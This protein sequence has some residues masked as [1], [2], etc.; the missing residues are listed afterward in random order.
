MKKGVFRKSLSLLLSAA[1]ALL[2]F[3]P[4]LAASDKQ[5]ETPVLIVTGFAEYPLG[6][7]QTGESAFPPETQDI[8]NTVAGAAPALLRLL[9]SDR[10]QADYDALCDAVLPVVNELFD[11]IACNPDGTVRHSDVGLLYQ[12]P[13]SA[14]DYPDGTIT[15]K[16][17]E[18]T[19]DQTSAVYGSVP[20]KLTGSYV[21][22]NGETQTGVTIT[23]T[24]R[25]GAVWPNA[26][27]YDLTAVIDDEFMQAA[28]LGSHCRE[29]EE[30]VAAVNVQ[31]VGNRTHTVRRIDVAVAVNRVIR[32]PL[33]FSVGRRTH[34]EFATGL[35]AVMLSV[36][37]L[38]IAKVVLVT[39]SRVQ[40]FTE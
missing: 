23:P 16:K 33:C 39:A 19:L 12:Y 2:L 17:V 6:N 35:I 27:T 32:T 25:D 30:A 22:V 8:I 40:Q 21:D 7:P 29:R 11:P 26:G 36:V 14:A 1:L 5:G 37:E 3:V 15:P 34:A 13:E 4:A 31:A 38:H 18:V 20:E 9:A 10:T 28:R 24:G